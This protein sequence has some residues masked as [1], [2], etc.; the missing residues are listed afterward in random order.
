MTAYGN[1]N[2]DQPLLHHVELETKPIDE[3]GTYSKRSLFHTHEIFIDR[4]CPCCGNSR[5]SISVF[6]D[7][8][9]FRHTQPSILGMEDCL[10]EGYFGVC[11]NPALHRDMLFTLFCKKVDKYTIQKVLRIFFTPVISKEVSIRYIGAPCTDEKCNRNHLIRFHGDFRKAI[12]KKL[13]YP[14]INQVFLREDEIMNIEKA[15]F[16]AGE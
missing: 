2:K 9:P 13:H 1:G 10:C 14:Q 15:L 8:Q 6:E 3:I 7:I 4:I 12:T 11:I 16:E 5:F